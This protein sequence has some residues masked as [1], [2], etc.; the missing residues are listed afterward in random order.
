MINC[1][2]YP[3][4]KHSARAFIAFDHY[5]G[6]P[7]AIILIPTDTSPAELNLTTPSTPVVVIA[8]ITTV[9]F[10]PAVVSLIVTGVAVT[11]GA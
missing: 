2:I 9:T 6:M 11:I 5:D 8:L 1:T 4:Y 10:L 3:V 7:T